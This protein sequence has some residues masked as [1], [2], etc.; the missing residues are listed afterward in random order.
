[1]DLLADLGSRILRVFFLPFGFLGLGPR[2][3]ARIQLIVSER[4]RE[5]VK[6]REVEVTVNKKA[7]H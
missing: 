1:M 4:G 3:F 2:F 6:E 5:G 7:F